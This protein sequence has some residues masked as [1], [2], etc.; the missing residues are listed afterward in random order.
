MITK[1]FV[2]IEVIPKIGKVAKATA[3][4]SVR[5]FSIEALQRIGG[6]LHYLGCHASAPVRQ[7]WHPVWDRFLKR[8]MKPYKMVMRGLVKEVI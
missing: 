4:R 2:V 3:Y 5:R 6:E 8:H 1:R 7:K